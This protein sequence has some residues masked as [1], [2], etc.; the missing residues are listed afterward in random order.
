MSYTFEDF[1]ANQIQKENLGME[2]TQE[3]GLLVFT[4]EEFG[5]FRYQHVDEWF[6]EL[7]Q[8]HPD[9]AFMYLDTFGL[10]DRVL[11]ESVHLILQR[12]NRLY[13][14]SATVKSKGYVVTP[15][16][17][18]RE[19]DEDYGTSVF[20]EQPSAAMFSLLIKDF[21][22]ALKTRYTWEKE[23]DEDETIPF[24]N[25]KKR[26]KHGIHSKNCEWIEETEEHLVLRGKGTNVEYHYRLHHGLSQ[27]LKEKG[28]PNVDVVHNCSFTDK[29]LR[30]EQYNLYF[31]HHTQLLK[32]EIQIQMHQTWQLLDVPIQYVNQDGGE[33]V[34]HEYEEE[35][36][37]FLQQEIMEAVKNL[38]EHRLYVVTGV[39][40]EKKEVIENQRRISN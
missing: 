31:Y 23:S 32:A 24:S 6:P 4:S 19:I 16:F 27:Y 22:A 20:M 13:N 15:R 39:L 7:K 29:E 18:Y 25:W 21:T 40:K 17:K 3:K 9:I 14:V 33:D 12:D 10:P 2:Y 30:G 35:D 37:V 5:V 38:P 11:S 26:F 8:K 28:I 1:V 36:L 34:N